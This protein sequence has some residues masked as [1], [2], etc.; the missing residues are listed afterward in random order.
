MWP[1]SLTVFSVIVRLRHISVIIIMMQS[2]MLFCIDMVSSRSSI[3]LA[4]DIAFVMKRLGSGGL[5][6]SFHSQACKCEAQQPH[7]CYLSLHRIHR[8]PG[9]TVILGDPSCLTSSV[10]IVCPKFSLLK[11]QP[12]CID[13]MFMLAV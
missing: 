8:F 12:L 6:G 4:R 9:R 13:L 11:R 2:C 7:I 3:L 10:I 5:C 1:A